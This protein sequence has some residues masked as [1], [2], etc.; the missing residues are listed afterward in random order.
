MFVVAFKTYKQL[1]FGYEI[2]CNVNMVG[3]KK[4][5]PLNNNQSEKTCFKI[6]AHI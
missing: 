5:L 4:M 1:T 3:A 6:R 2:N